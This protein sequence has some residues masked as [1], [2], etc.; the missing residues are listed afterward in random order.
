MNVGSDATPRA[1][2]DEQGIDYFVRSPLLRFYSQLSVRARK[3]M[4]QTF[5]RLIA[6]APDAKILDVGVTPNQTM[7]GFNFFEALYPHPENITA[8]SI[9]DASY[10]EVKYPGLRFVKTEGVTLP[11]R[12]AEFDVV[13]CL[14]VIEHV[15]NRQQQARFA[16]E[17]L[18]VG[19]RVFVTT[20]NRG[21]PMELHTFVP[22]IHWLPQRA[23]QALLRMLGLR[24]W[25]QTENLNLLGKRNLLGLFPPE[26][27]V[28]LTGH[29][30][31]GMTS[32]LIAYR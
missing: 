2:D 5:M 27:G 21:F 10:L 25:A 24:F 3:N 1:K 31:L 8:T 22:L 11:F 18:R 16:R 30:L 28:K 12:D 17:L 29:A 20:P 14:A 26:S 4:Y 23:H 15:G 7:P 6:P 9:E 19:R 32:N 13:V